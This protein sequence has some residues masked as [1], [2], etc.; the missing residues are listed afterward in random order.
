MNNII[1]DIPSD[2][3]PHIAQHFDD[4]FLYQL[5][6]SLL[7]KKIMDCVCLT[8]FWKY[9]TEIA[10]KKKLDDIGNFYDTLI[11]LD[12]YRTIEKSILDENPLAC[13][14]ESGH[15]QALDILLLKHNPS[16]NPYILMKAA[17]SKNMHKIIKIIMSD[18][19]LS[20]NDYKYI[21]LDYAIRYGRTKTVD[22]LI[23]NYDFTDFEINNNFLIDSA[24]GKIM[25]TRLVMLPDSRGGL[26]NN[27]HALKFFTPIYANL[28]SY[29]LNIGENMSTLSEH[30]RS[31]DPNPECDHFELANIFTVSLGQ[32]IVDISMSNQSHIVKRLLQLNGIDPSAQNDQALINAVTHNEIDIVKMLLN[33]NKVNPNCHNGEPIIIAARSGY[34]EIV[35][36]LLNDSRVDP[37]LRNSQ[38]IIN[39]VDTTNVKNII[40]FFPVKQ[41]RI[42]YNRIK[43]NSKIKHLE[44]LKLMLKN[45]KINPSTQNNK[46]FITAVVSKNYEA[47]KLL[48]KDI[49]VN[50]FDQNFSALERCIILKDTKLN[51]CYKNNMLLIN[52]TKNYDIKLVE[53]LLTDPRI[54]LDDIYVDNTSEIPWY[55]EFLKTFPRDNIVKNLSER[56]NENF[57]NMK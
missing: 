31:A 23:D 53:L 27:I 44:I 28:I 24:V 35:E 29:M 46:T 25:Q 54:N 18:G 37:S 41:H 1:K 11:W 12:I 17:K 19:R 55:I 14:S 43:Q 52:A 36:I 21:V 47:V 15:Y 8:S 3:F 38:A 5:M 20:I 49:R 30:I 16:K 57:N 22:L 39:C 50:P 42:V 48:L 33:N 7:K 10:I 45:P 2:I 32:D 40:L 34:L 26:L 4:I 9:K 6:H 56:K 13:V 51:P